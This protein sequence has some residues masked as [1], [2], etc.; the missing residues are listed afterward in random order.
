MRKY[1]DN[2][3]ELIR[4]TLNMYKS[5]ILCTE[6]MIKYE[7]QDGGLLHSLIAD[8]NPSNYSINELLKQN[9]D[10][11]QMI[12]LL[13]SLKKI[14]EEKRIWVTINTQSVIDEKPLRND[15][16]INPKESYDTNWENRIVVEVKNDKDYDNFSERL[17]KFLKDIGIQSYAYFNKMDK[18]IIIN[19][20]KEKK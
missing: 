11:I 20:I 1:D 13:L 17:I 6:W 8:D 10:D 12:D 3:F 18:E 15:L 9:K 2:G 19:A 4:P 7:E 14:S 16:Y 5:L